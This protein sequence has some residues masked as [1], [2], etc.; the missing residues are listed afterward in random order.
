MK[1]R[2]VA[3]H[4][5]TR[6]ISRGEIQLELEAVL[7]SP[8]FLR[9]QRLS[10]F[11]RFIV[12][13]TLGGKK[14]LKEYTLGMEVFDHPASFDPR[15]D[16]GV[17]VEAGRL[18]TK[19][20]HHYRTLGRKATILITVLKGSYVPVFSR[21]SREPAK[22]G[23]ITR[24]RRELE[25][26]NLALAS[27]HNE[28][29]AT[30]EKVG[31]ANEELQVINE[32]LTETSL[33]LQTQNQEL[34]AVQE[35]IQPCFLAINR[36]NLFLKHVLGR[37][38]I[39]VLIVDPEMRIAAWNE[40]VEEFWDLRKELFE[41]EIL[42]ALDSGFPVERLKSRIKACLAGSQELEFTLRNG[43]KPFRFRM[44]PAPIYSPHEK[45]GAVILVIQELEDSVQL[46]PPPT[47]TRPED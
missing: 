27:A 39:G 46:C 31:A 5:L 42:F 33:Q 47:D 12:E 21:R 4:S 3:G 1:A 7:K 9:S 29:Q 43:G 8:A 2:G 28:I 25:A 16:P 18:R 13:Q 37:L 32:R 19:L 34:T 17:R 36:T 40:K 11:L 20:R 38:G 23:E 24:L 41:G 35:T 10:R 45:P 14:G 22:A 26:S 30:L 6:A 44:L 15:I